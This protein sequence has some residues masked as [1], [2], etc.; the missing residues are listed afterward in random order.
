MMGAC[1]YAPEPPA[2]TQTED[3]VHE[4]ELT[5]DTLPPRTLSL[6]YD[7]GPDAHT[8]ELA[9]Y[10]HHEG[11]RA[12]FFVNGCRFHGSP[13]P[14]Q[15]SGNCRDT[16]QVDVSIL[17]EL[18]ALGHRVAN[19]T[20][21]HPDLTTLVS[22]PATI[23]SQVRLTQ[24]VID[25]YIT[26]GFYLLR[27]PYGAWNRNVAQAA[28][29]PL[30]QKITG[31]INWDISGDDVACFEDG[32]PASACGEQYLAAIKARPRMNGVVL[33]HDRLE[34]NVGSTSALELTMWLVPNLRRENFTF[35]P[36]DAI[37]NLPGTKTSGD[38]RVWT[39]DFARS[40]VSPRF[41][42]IDGDGRADVCG[43]S[44][45]GI[46]CARSA[47][48]TFEVSRSWLAT[49]FTDALGW[50]DEAFASTIALGDIDGDHR[51][52]VC[53]RGVYGIS[54]ALSTGSSFG[55]ARLW[56]T[57][58]DFGL[59]TSTTI[60]TLQLGDV[61]GDG[62]ADVCGRTRDGIRCALSDG[63]HF[64]PQTLWM[65]RD[66]TDDRG[67]NE[68][69]YDTTIRLGDIDGDGRADVCGRGAPGL[70]CSL[71]T[72]A[73][74]GAPTIHP[75]FGDLDGWSASPSRYRSIHLAD[76][77]GDGRADVCGRSA[78]GIVCAFG[79]RDG[80]FE[81]YHYLDNRDYRD[82]LGWS[83][84]ELGATV[85]LADVDGD[86]HADVCGRGFA[87]ILCAKSP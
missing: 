46:E 14:I 39:S 65:G 35:V 45:A 8:I 80:A 53:G 33:L 69:A 31:P 82:D 7:D 76:V 73:G 26:D 28:D 49:E 54:C 1:T 15:A 56:S 16:P 21:D 22:D 66:F 19:H 83:A 50:D 37:P 87:G 84:P 18:T 12:T 29:S 42:D 17:A 47:G 86:G 68:P 48:T 13:T 51:A 81:R 36:L 63:S 58:H 57:A 38:T 59:G 41:A 79:T 52:D 10:L 75:A 3:L 67:W 85:T 27:P 34:F 64:A 61:N 5:G 44:S 6:T 2:A 72:G 30:L 43:R 62:R 25:P 24:A 32:Q 60:T 9:T 71:S 70:I 40:H 20:E 23:I 55:P 74:F 11:I 77:D 4:H 78:T